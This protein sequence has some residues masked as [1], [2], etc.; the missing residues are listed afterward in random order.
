MTVEITIKHDVKIKDILRDYEQFK[1]DGSSFTLEDVIEN[2]F[3]VFMDDIFDKYTLYNF[4]VDCKKAI[5]KT[6]KALD[7]KV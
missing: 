2:Y 6:K 4:E 3:E 5:E 7:K 1:D